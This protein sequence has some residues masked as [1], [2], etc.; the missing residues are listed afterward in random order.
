MRCQPSSLVRSKPLVRFW[1]L[2]P[3]ARASAAFVL[4]TGE[5][6]AIVKMAVGAHEREVGSIRVRV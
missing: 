4:T 2:H 5:P 1:T 6:S 3:L